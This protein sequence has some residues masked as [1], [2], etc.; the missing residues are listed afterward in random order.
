[1][2]TRGRAPWAGRGP[3]RA[4]AEVLERPRYEVLPLPGVDEEVAEHLPPQ[5]TV[6]IT[7][8]AR[9]GMTATMA[10]A[11]RLATRGLTVVPHLSARSIGDEAQLKEI[12]DEVVRLG[13]HEVFVVGGD[14][15][16]PAGT[17]TGSLDLL[18]AMDRL[19]YDPAVGLAGH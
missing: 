4:L 18:V 13:I 19:R 8:S 5:A 9:R 16:E 2:L 11:E 14:A 12:L 15:D 6:T 7:A 17:F 3:R 1:M 10:L